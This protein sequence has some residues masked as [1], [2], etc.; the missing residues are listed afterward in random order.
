VR[1]FKLAHKI[2]SRKITKFIT[3][4]ALRSKAIFE[5]KSNRFIDNVSN[6][7]L[8]FGTENVYNSSQSN[9]QLEFCASC[10]LAREKCQKN[11]DCNLISICNYTQHS[12][13]IQL[14]ISDYRLLSLLLIM[15]KEISKTLDPIV[16]TIL[17]Q[18]TISL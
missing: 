17:K 7:I 12:Y 4:K 10:T 3:K 2:I 8:R 11:R 15:L 13:T 6:I 18:R 5:T 1:R 14:I 9:L 16:Q